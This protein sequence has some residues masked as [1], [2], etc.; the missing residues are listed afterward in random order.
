MQRSLGLLVL[1]TTSTVAVRTAAADTLQVPAQY[2][3]I[4]AAV[5]A[6]D[7]GDEIVVADGVWTGPGNRDIQLRGLDI[8]VRSANGPAQCTLDIQGTTA[9]PYRGFLIQGGETRATQIDGFTLRGGATLPGAIADEFNGGGIRILSS[10]P[11]IRNCVFENNQSGCWGGALYSGHGGAPLVTACTFRDNRSTDGG[12]IFS[13]NEAAPE[14]TSCL[15][16]DNTAASVGGAITAF[17]WITIR[18]VTIVGGDASYASAVYAFEGEMSN[19]IVWGN[20]AFP[21]EG[22]V[23]VRYSIVEGGH[24]GVGNL[25]VFPRFAADGYHLLPGSPAIGAGDPASVPP[26]D[27]LDIDGEPRRFMARV[28]MGADEFRFQAG[29]PR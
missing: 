7:P 18:N 24:Q 14:V 10:S 2:P 23:P 20:A 12:A 8:V 1:A 25:D 16:I 6:A 9:E 3:S 21:I 15:F 26:A 28:D 29:T 11:T 17:D 4:Q 5:D 22:A 27:E 19:S 13:W